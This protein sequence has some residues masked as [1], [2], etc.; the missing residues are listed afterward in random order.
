[1]LF[2]LD[3]F[4]NYK[5]PQKKL[6]LKIIFKSSGFGIQDSTVNPLVFKNYPWRNF[7]HSSLLQFKKITKREKKERKIVYLF[8]F[9]IRKDFC[10]HLNCSFWKSYWKNNTTSV[11]VYSSWLCQDC[12]L[13][14]ILGFIPKTCLLDSV[15]VCFLP[16]HTHTALKIPLLRL[17]A[18]TYC[19]TLLGNVCSNLKQTLP[20]CASH[21]DTEMH[22][23]V[24]VLK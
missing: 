12:T 23:N 24:D 4:V 8:V 21:H 1:M 20:V 2:F 7:K 18:L 17:S 19:G 15:F 16:F 5:I 14:Y 3:L 6:A 13:A 11:L 9:V 10:F 22:M